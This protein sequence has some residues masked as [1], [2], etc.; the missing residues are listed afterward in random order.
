M[1]K[2]ASTQLSVGVNPSRNRLGFPGST[3]FWALVPVA[4]LAAL[5][6]AGCAS[7]SRMTNRPDREPEHSTIA[8]D[9]STVPAGRTIP[10]AGIGVD[11]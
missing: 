8:T 5:F 4:A 9:P 6:C 11:L 2:T 3:S 7:H 10:P 1:S